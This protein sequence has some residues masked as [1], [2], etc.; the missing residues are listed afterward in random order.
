MTRVEKQ[1][2]G[3]KR[4]KLLRYQNVIAFYH[5]VKAENKYISI[6]DLHKDFIYP[7]FH[8]S[9]TTLYNILSTPVKKELKEIKEIES[10]QID[11][12]AS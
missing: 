8:I 12:F 5:K 7:E 9:R 3:T 1:K 6:V 11:L 4:N 10:T 2:L